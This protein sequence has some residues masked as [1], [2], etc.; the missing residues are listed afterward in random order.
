MLTAFLGS[1]LIT[2]SAQA[3]VV[4]ELIN[5][6]FEQD[7]G[8]PDRAYDWQDFGSGYT[9]VNVARTGS[10]GIKL[11]NESSGQMSGAYQRIDFQ[12]TTLKPVFVGAYVKGSGIA[13]NS[14][15]WLGAGLYVEIHLQDGSVVYWNSVANYGTFDW[16]WIGF[17][18]GTV[19]WVNQPIDHIFLIPIL[20]QAVGTAYFDDLTITEYDPYQSAVTFMFDDGEIGVWHNAKPIMD[21][22][23]FDG[24]TAIIT[25]ELG[26]PGFLRGVQLQALQRAGWEIISHGVDHVDLTTLGNRGL[27]NELINSRSVLRR[28]GLTINNFA[29]P[30]GA[31]NSK[32]LAT[33]AEYYRSL[34]AFE[35][36]DNPQGLFPYDVKVRG[37]QSTTTPTE[38]EGWVNQAMANQRWLLLV[39]HKIDSQGDDEYHTDPAVFSQMTKIISDSGIDVIT[40][41]QALDRFGVRN[42]TVVPPPTTAHVCP[43]PTCATVIG[44]TVIA[45]E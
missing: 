1:F 17:N 13:L 15:G 44:T 19:P 16:R 4:D 27:R 35:T 8:Q 2:L 11:K 20:S 14:G 34:R 7:W 12:Q 3:Q 26:S 40:Y 37:V 28:L 29:I 24:S 10:W 45:I 33:G 41:N 25:S 32:V 9:R 21:E 38:V 5:P 36:G 31:Y 18:T 23:G 42:T 22:Y 30:F 43:G 39:F 6:S